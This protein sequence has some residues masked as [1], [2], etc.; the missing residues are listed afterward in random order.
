M[1]LNIMTEIYIKFSWFMPALL[2]K[3]RLLMAIN[4]W[5][6]ASENMIRRTSQRDSVWQ[7]LRHAKRH[8][9]KFENGLKEH[10]TH[11]M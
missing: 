1:A 8:L 4:D 6:Q 10:M 7:D 3:T 5:E 2:E 11:N 9:N